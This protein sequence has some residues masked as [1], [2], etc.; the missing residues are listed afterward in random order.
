MNEEKILE[1]MDTE[2]I[3]A[4]ESSF[5]SD[6]IEDSKKT[7]IIVDFWAPWCGPCK[8]LT[9]VLEE[10]VKKTKGKVKLAKI[11]IDE[12]QNIAQQLRIQSIPM[13]Y[14]FV[15]GKPIDGFAGV[16]SKSEI[17]TFI[18]KISNSTTQA[19]EQIN[20]AR[21]TMDKAE[22][23][24]KNNNVDEALSDFSQL[25]D[26]DLPKEDLARTI[27]GLG[28]CLLA[29]GDIEEVKNLLD[30]L[31]QD[32]AELPHIESLKSSLQLLGS[33]DKNLDLDIIY[34][35][36]ENNKNDL[37]L[38]FQ[39]AEALIVNG[40]NEDAINHLI[41]IIKKDR[42]WNNSLARNKLLELFKAL[43][44]TDNITIEG[45]KKLSAILFS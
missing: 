44:D 26:L 23:K 30:G 38:K 35:K 12:N 16:I 32:M 31:D 28:K 15:D 33:A 9:P 7:P 21:I 39:L 22:E 6:I 4:D 37:N 45:R 40:M 27:S 42:N 1:K 29:K 19:Q 2:I 8:Q 41:E 36:L 11:N 10:E 25:M 17:K 24:L 5:V 14:A 43:G 18:E 13:V 34:K 20:N 3:N